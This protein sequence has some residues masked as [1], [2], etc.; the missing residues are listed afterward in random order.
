[1]NAPKLA[2]SIRQPWA[3]LIVNG[4]KDLENRNW[5]THFRG[6]IFVHAAKGMTGAEYG[7]CREFALRI[8]PAIPFPEFDDLPRGGIVGAV[9]VTGCVCDSPSPWFVGDFGFTLANPELLAFRPSRGA[10]GFFKPEE[11]AR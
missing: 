5:R 1:M 8:R 7:D 3:W 10:L 6:R 2:L 4:F 11:F 9:D